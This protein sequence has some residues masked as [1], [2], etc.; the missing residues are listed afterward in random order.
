MARTA[1]VPALI[2]ESRHQSWRSRSTMRQ[3]RVTARLSR[4]SCSFVDRPHHAKEPVGSA[5]GRHALSGSGRQP[6]AVS[7]SS[8]WK[9]AL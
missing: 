2:S 9:R 7:R 5:A 8:G 4:S 3:A 6:I 1:I